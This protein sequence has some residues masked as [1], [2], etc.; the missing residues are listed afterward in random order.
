MKPDSV[1]LTWS[2]PKDDGGSKIDSYYILMREDDGEFKEIAKLKSFDND[3]KIKDLVPGKNYFFA[4]VAGNKMGKGEAMETSTPTV[5]KKKATKPSAPVGPIEFSDIQKTSVVISWKPCEDDG[6]SPLTGYY[7]EN[8][9]ASKSTW[10]RVT[11]VN[12]DITSYC[13]QRLK[14]RQE[15]FFRVFAENKVGRSD[16]LVSDGVTVKSQFGTY[17]IFLIQHLLDPKNK[18]FRQIPVWK[19]SDQTLVY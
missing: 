16:A 8:R 2:K 11:T 12:P 4:V 19:I 18:I 6:G 13:V 14:E 10:T 7:I 17:K 15:Y 1:T 3:Y 5:L 9:E